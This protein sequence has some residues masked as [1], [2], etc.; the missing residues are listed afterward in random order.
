MLTSCYFV[1][2]YWFLWFTP[3]LW[4]AVGHSIW[5]HSRWACWC[6]FK[7]FTYAPWTDFGVNE[8]RLLL[9]RCFTDD[10]DKPGWPELPFWHLAFFFFFFFFL[11]CSRRFSLYREW[12]SHVQWADQSKLFP[13]DMWPTSPITGR[14]GGR[15]CR[16]T[17]SLHTEM[18]TL[19]RVI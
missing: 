18:L 4:W 16:L 19:R 1:A 12:P 6:D 7:K 10:D 8:W 11:L 13:L 2:L 3:G 14:N 9:A 17:L 5:T 15:T